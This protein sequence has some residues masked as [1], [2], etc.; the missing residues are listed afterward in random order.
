M[1]SI[2]TLLTV[3]CVATLGFT[4]CSS[5]S[6]CQS[7]TQKT[8]PMTKK[9]CTSQTGCCASSTGTCPVKKSCSTNN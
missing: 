6:T 4:G 1:K 3:A 9:A 7:G 8:C 5:P 2:L